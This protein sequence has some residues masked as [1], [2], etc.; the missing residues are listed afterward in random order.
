ML[1]EINKNGVPE[2]ETGPQKI[3]E[4]K[5]MASEQRTNNKFHNAQWTAM[6][7]DIKE[8]GVPSEK[9]GRSNRRIGQ[10]AVGDF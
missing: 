7:K 6:I 9:T 1:A 2:L 4:V 3:T 8:N 10:P 5:F